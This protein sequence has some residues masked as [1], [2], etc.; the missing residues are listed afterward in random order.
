M[1]VDFDNLRKQLV[2]NFN[3]LTEKLN[4]AIKD[5]SW[6]PEIIIDVCQIQREMDSIRSCLITLAFL[7]QHGENGFDTLEDD[8]YFETFNNKIE[9]Q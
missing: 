5:S 6:D 1:E 4:N 7:Y 2:N 8:V 3:S 9:Q